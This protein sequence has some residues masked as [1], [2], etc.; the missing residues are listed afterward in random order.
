M[1]DMGRTL[2]NDPGRRRNIR[3]SVSA[4]VRK[5][6]R[7]LKV[8]LWFMRS[9]ASPSNAVRQSRLPRR[10][11]RRLRAQGFFPHKFFVYGF[12]KRDD[13]QSFLSD[14][15]MFMSSWIDGE[16]AVMLE[17]KLR[18]YLMMRDLVHVPHVFLSVNQGVPTWIHGGTPPD[19]DIL[20]L[21]E[22]ERN[23][24]V[25]PVLG[26]TGKGVYLLSAKDGAW[27]RDGEQV[28]EG[29]LRK[30]VYDAGNVIVVE[31][32]EQS[33]FGNRIYP[34]SANTMRV[35][36]ML[37]PDDGDPFVA[38][39]RHRFGTDK[40]APTDNVSRGGMSCDI[41]LETGRL[42]DAIFPSPL[43]GTRTI[44]A[45]PQTQLVFREQVIPDWPDLV[46]RIVAISAKLPMLPYIAWDLVLTDDGLCAIE[47][48]HW[49]QVY[50]FQTTGPW[51]ANPRI[52][53]FFEYHGIVP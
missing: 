48:N 4:A 45:H 51:L 32:I 25:K 27:L 43:N 50:S 15:Q 35:V 39:A 29:E 2:K 3:Q 38:A 17:D 49:T 23:V 30:L 20:G 36:T 5:A 37:D 11:R 8:A 53:R 18:F 16:H 6:H 33:A 19:G 10:I 7:R 24:V 12:D 9:A 34:G 1:D 42:G 21:L 13:W 28:T 26:Q 44:D 41:D 52:R 46:D 14:R 40:S 31:S 47:A 22:R